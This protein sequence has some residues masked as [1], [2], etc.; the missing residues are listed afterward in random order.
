MSNDI[1]KMIFTAHR[2]KSLCLEFILIVII[3]QRFFFDDVQFD[4]IQADDLELNSTLFTIHGLAF[5]HIEID[6]NVGIAF[7]T[8]SGRHFFYLQ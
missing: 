4:W 1:W 3:I 7:R 5:V 8:R 6:M 2:I